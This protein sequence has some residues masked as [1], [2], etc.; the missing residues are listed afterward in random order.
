MLGQVTCSVRWFGGSAAHER[1]GSW[2]RN[3][4]RVC[5]GTQ[6]VALLAVHV[7]HQVR[8]CPHPFT[9]LLFHVAH[10]TDRKST[11]LRHRSS[12]PRRRFHLVFT[13]H[14]ARLITN[15]ISRRYE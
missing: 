14:R 4:G 1:S 15:A 13:Q 7:C 10:R 5:P 6:L 2:R 3:P 8:Y 11:L 9:D 12:D